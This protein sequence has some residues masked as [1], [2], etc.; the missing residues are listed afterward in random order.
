[1]KHG[2]ILILIVVIV[3]IAIVIYFVY[4]SSSTNGTATTNGTNLVSTAPAVFPVIRTAMTPVTDPATRY[5]SSARP[6]I[7]LN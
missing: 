7:N 3:V 4:Q 6:S 5:V 2:R 1:M